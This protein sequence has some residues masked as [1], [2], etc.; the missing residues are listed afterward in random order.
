MKIQFT[1]GESN[2]QEPK[3]TKN[4]INHLSFII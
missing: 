1:I 3:K 4:S 2:D